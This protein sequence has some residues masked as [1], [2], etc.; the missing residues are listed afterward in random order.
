MKSGSRDA[1]VSDEVIELSR[2]R[3][4][5]EAAEAAEDDSV[6]GETVPEDEAIEQVA[7]AHAASEASDDGELG[8]FD[9]DDGGGSA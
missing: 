5:L 9:P 2:S 8:N 4:E 7:E 1:D 3:V 6:T